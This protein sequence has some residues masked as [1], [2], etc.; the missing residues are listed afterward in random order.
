MK[1]FLKTV[2]RVRYDQ[3]TA[4]ALSEESAS[5]TFENFPGPLH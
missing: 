4:M 3:S 5:E 2:E 1:A